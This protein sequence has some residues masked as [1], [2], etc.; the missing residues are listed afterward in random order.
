M[1]HRN[2]VD[3]NEL[4][5]GLTDKPHSLSSLL[6]LKWLFLQEVCFVDSVKVHS[7]YN[8]TVLVF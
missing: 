5:Y 7:P 2:K 4:S 6:L 3:I 1:G 8:K